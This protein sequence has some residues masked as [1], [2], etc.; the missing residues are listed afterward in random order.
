M[1][2]PA[3]P[4]GWTI[5]DLGRARTRL[6]L[7][8]AAPRDR[9]D[10]MEFRGDDK[11]DNDQDLPVPE[12]LARLRD[13]AARGCTAIARIA[14][15]D[16]PGWWPE[17]AWGGYRQDTVRGVLVHLLNDNAGVGGEH[18]GFP[19]PPRPQ[20]P[21]CRPPMLCVSSRGETSRGRG[22]IRPEDNDPDRPQYLIKTP[23]A[24]VSEPGSMV[25]QGFITA[26]A[27]VSGEPGEER[28]DDAARRRDRFRYATAARQDDSGYCQGVIRR[29][30][31]RSRQAGA[32]RSA[33]CPD[34]VGCRH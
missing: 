14:S 10:P 18:H 33:W 25:R 8:L 28:T 3:A 26:Y 16:A 32:S 30:C 4:S 20:P 21:A 23:S 7:V 6:D 11:W 19:L 29:R 5:A 1:R 13:D 17:G 2:I 15:S 27:H 24:E 9:G 12:L 34:R 31:N 22:R